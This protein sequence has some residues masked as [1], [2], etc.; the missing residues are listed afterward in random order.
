[1]KKTAKILG[2]IAAALLVGGMI[3]ACTHAAGGIGALT[4][5]DIN[6]NYENHEKDIPKED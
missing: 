5:P 2:I 1:M 3:I 4:Q 6:P